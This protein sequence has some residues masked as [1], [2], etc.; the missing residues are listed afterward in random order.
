MDNNI[1]S[2]IDH[3][4]WLLNNG[5][6]HDSVKNNLFM[7]GSIAHKDVIAVDMSIDV[8]KKS[9][10]YSLFFSKKTK[11][12]IELFNRLRGKDD[13]I[14][15]FRLKRL[16]KKHGNLDLFSIL[17]NFIKDYCGPGWRVTV[18]VM[19]YDDYVEDD[20]GRDT[21]GDEEVS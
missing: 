14:S 2:L 20:Y 15:L 7:Y 21:D 17:N 13:L 11:K 5:I 6:V 9:V 4:R 10:S 16:L 18:K 12:V 8:S 3:Q 19:D 1:A